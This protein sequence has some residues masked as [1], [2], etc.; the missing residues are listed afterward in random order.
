MITPQG[1]RKAIEYFEQAITME[2][3]Y[4]L[5]YALAARAYSRLGATGQMLPVD[6]FRIVHEYAD[7]AV[8]LD[9]SIAESHIAKAGIYLL[10]EWRWNEAYDS[11]Q[12]AI[13]LNPAAV[14]AYQLMSFH[15]LVTAQ[16]NKAVEIMEEAEQIDPLSP[17]VMLALGNMYAFAKRYDDGITQSE[18]M[19]A[20]QPEMR[21]AIELKAWC[22]GMAGN[23]E[24]ALILF[25]ELH[26]L[27]NHPLK[28]IMGLAFAYGKLG[29]HEEAIDLIS[30][31]E[32]RQLQE[33]GSVI[34]MELACAWF[35]MGDIDKSFYYLD[36]CVDKKVGPVSY[37][38]E[39]PVFEVV[40]KD[41][42]YAA[43]KRKMGLEAID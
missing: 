30:R 41:P 43:L 40:K 24:Q 26:E 36:Q 8:Q 6:A 37:F 29:R 1:L 12:R 22:T 25:K 3:G 4:A 2:P 9:D 14:E 16:T 17:Q 35:G 31:M 32:Q 33:P 27:T 13:S 19:L 21:S 23:W 15:F 20:L 7:K 10:Y 28:G 11:L 34:D 18:K 42:R 39:Y 5:A 38:L